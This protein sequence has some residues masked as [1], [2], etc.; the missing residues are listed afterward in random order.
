MNKRIVNTAK[1]AGTSGTVAFALVAILVYFL[2]QLKEIESALTVLTSFTINIILAK[3]GVIADNE[4]G[5][6]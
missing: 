6:S 4:T 3:T 5:S 2:P 1:Y